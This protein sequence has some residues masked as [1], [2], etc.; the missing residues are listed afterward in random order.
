M[1]E[2]L[3]E[4]IL[5]ISSLTLIDNVK[6]SA[7][8]I[9]LT[10]DKFNCEKKI[11]ELAKRIGYDKARLQLRNTN[12]CGVYTDKHRYDIDG[13]RYHSCLCGYRE[14]N[15]G[16]LFELSGQLEKGILPFDGCYMD[17]PAQI[18]EMLERL[19]SLK[20]DKQNRDNKKQQ[21]QNKLKES[22]SGRR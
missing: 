20:L 19:N 13:I 16:V 21:N 18:M 22:R 14:Y 12:G 8:F 4:N 3:Y 2:L 1:F 7:T 5:R 6:I 17:Q 11:D 15:I 10:E 9:Y